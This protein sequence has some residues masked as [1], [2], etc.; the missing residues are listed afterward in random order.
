MLEKFCKRPVGLTEIRRDGKDNDAIINVIKE[1]YNV[2]EEKGM[3]MEEISNH[4][5]VFASACW[6]SILVK[7]LNK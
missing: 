2:C 1:E 5:E 3:T 7:N 6:V 4:M